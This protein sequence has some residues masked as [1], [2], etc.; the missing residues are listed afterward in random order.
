MKKIFAYIFIFSL[1]GIFV[2]PTLIF[3]GNKK[4]G[5]QCGNLDC[6]S[7]D[8]ESSNLELPNKNFCVCDEAQ[9]CLNNYQEGSVTDWKCSDEHEGNYYEL[10]YCEK[11]NE[12]DTYTPI[13]PLAQTT[14]PIILKAVEKSGD[15]S[16]SNALNAITD[17][18]GSL[19]KF[20]SE[21]AQILQ[22]PQP[23]INIPGLNFSEINIDEMVTMDNEGTAWLNIPFMGEYLSAVYKYAVVVMGLIA[24]IGLM[25]GGILWIM[26]GGSSERKQGAQKR[27]MGSVIGI[28]IV[29]TSY[30]LLYTINPELVQFRNLKVQYIKPID[31]GEHTEYNLSEDQEKIALIQMPCEGDTPPTP[32]V[33]TTGN[34]QFL[35]IYDCKMTKKRK[36][37]DIK[38]VIIHEGGRSAAGT[39]GTWNKRSIGLNYQ[40]GAHYIIERSGEIFQIVGEER[41]GNHAGGGNTKSIGID[42][43][44]PKNC[45]QSPKS[46]SFKTCSNYEQAQYDSLKKLI[47]EIVSRTSVIFNNIQVMGH[48][49]IKKSTHADPRGFQWEKIGLDTTKHRSDALA[50]PCIKNFP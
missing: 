14:D 41:V 10:H 25:H 35:G 5:E 49:Q 47:E 27:I 23:K 20:Q 40:L 43:A 2:F 12:D 3:A 50:G 30:I 46:S 8:C 29:S 16:L 11:K 24:V 28:V 32:S 17:P 9:D 38:Y 4:I 1:I 6:A 19:A 7:G 26:S 42:L 13:N 39:V 31:I 44:I 48:C 33:Y 21:I 18:E 45:S 15:F 36:L 22:K 37:S 34:K